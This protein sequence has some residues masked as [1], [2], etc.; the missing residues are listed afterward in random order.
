MHTLNRLPLNVRFLTFALA[1]LAS[2]A[3][4]TAPAS[5]ASQPAGTQAPLQMGELVVTGTRASVISAIETKREKLEIVDSIVASDINKLPDYNV[6][7]ALQRI[8]GIQILRDRGEGAG[9]SIRGLTQMETVLNGREIFTAGL[10]STGSASRIVDFADIPAEMVS[11]INVYKTSSAEHIEGGIGGLVDM[12]TRRPFDF[13]GLEAVGSARLIHGDLVDKWKPQYSAL[14]SQRWKLAG[15]G[16]FGALLNVTFQDRAWRED[17]KGT[18]NPLAR[19][20]IMPG[21][22][23]TV[24]NSTSE[25]TVFGTR[26]RLGATGVLQWRPTSTLELYVEGNY[27]K[28]D[29]LQDTNQIN[30]SG[31]TFVP[32]SATL[33]PG[34]TDLQRITWTNAAV[35]VLSFARDTHDWTKQIAGGA[36]WRGADLTIK[37]DASYTKSYNDLFFSGPFFALM[38]V[39][40]RIR[41]SLRSERMK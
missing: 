18:G 2:A 35:S 36:I 32:G 41:P 15:G 27:T 13:K 11:A 24:Q 19:T 9:I 16:E 26:E 7:D 3:A 25:N 31:T 34:T 12:Q 14:V 38:T 37:A 20:D 6:T 8:T 1:G 10:G 40:Y 21:Q 39:T 30:A 4:Q 28:F 29:T 17:Q 5:N 22:T 23:I 33:W